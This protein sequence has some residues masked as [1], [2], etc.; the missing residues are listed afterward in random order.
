MVFD[1]EKL[2]EEISSDSNETDLDGKLITG[3]KTTLYEIA[4]NDDLTEMEHYLKDRRIHAISK[5]TIDL[6]AVV[7][8]PARGK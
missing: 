3:L 2:K 6:W 4:D 8:S 1:I 7:S 5:I